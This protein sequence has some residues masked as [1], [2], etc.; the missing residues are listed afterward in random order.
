LADAPEAGARWAAVPESLNSAKKLKALEKSFADFLYNSARLTLL[1]NSKLGLVGNPG[2]D[3]LAFR[4]RCRSAARHEAEKALAAEKI[5]YQPRFEALGASLPGEAS[6]PQ[7]GIT[8]L[9]DLV[10]PWK[11]FQNAPSETQAAKGAER[12]TRQQDAVRKLEA[13]WHAKQAGTWEKWKQVGE[14]YAEVP[15]T[16]RRAD[17]RVTHF[18]LAWAPFWQVRAGD[19]APQLVPA[20]R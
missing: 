17:V 3:V 13:E 2:E 6:G 1:E 14:E 9:L 12:G 4:E 5:R 15:L 20:Y 16:P 18:G 19:G 11:F 10:N 8:S 7:R